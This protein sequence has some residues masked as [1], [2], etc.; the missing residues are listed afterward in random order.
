MPTLKRHMASFPLVL[1]E[2]LGTFIFKNIQRQDANENVNTKTC[3]TLF[4]AFLLSFLHYYDVKMPN[5]AFYGE[6][7]KMNDEISFSA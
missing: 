3:I 4:C 6:R 2:T 1:Q 7:K 5:F